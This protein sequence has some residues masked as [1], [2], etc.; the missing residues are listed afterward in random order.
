MK[1]FLPLFLLPLF[2]FAHQ[3]REN[4]LHTDYNTTTKQLTL[5]FEIETRL[6][7]K[8]SIDDNHNEIISFKEL[9][10]HKEQLLKE[11]LPHIHLS[12][13]DK[14]LSLNDPKITFHRYKTQTYM[15][16][17]KSFKNVTL[18]GLKLHYDLF[19]NQNKSYKLL[20]HLPKKQDA[21]LN[22]SHQSYTFTTD[23]MSQWQRF[24]LFVKEGILHILD[25]TDHLLFILML[26]I[27]SVLSYAETKNGLKKSLISL[28]KI[29]TTFSV[30][31]SVTLFIA[32]MGLYTPNS[33]II[34][35]GIALSIFIVALLNL[36]QKYSHVSYG[37]VFAFGLIHGFGFANVLEIAGVKESLSFIVAL[38]GFNIGVEIGQISVIL[39]TL[40]LLFFI[41]KQ[42]WHMFVVKTIIF[43]TMG[44]SAWWF[45]QRVGLV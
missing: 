32:G 27:P 35:S 24:K 19:F 10:A 36:L 11:I 43:M 40:P 22:R 1:I 30:A 18:N 45:F 20:I 15:E 44:I 23:T 7:E 4:Y 17:K 39:L 31:H 42:Q 5:S 28:L 3:L 21:V 38:F 12:Y 41:M 33:M 13:Q 8:S 9:Y 14:A 34:E 6:L 29:V 2:L 26:L 25:G 37:I 16:L